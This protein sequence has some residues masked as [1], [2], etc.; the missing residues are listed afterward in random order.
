MFEYLIDDKFVCSNDKIAVG[1]SGGADSMLLLWALIDK[2]K[3]LGFEMLVIHINHGIRKETS[4]RDQKFVEDFCKKRK[5]NQISIKIDTKKLKNSE[6]LTLEEAA[7]TLRY[8]AFKKVIKEQKCNKLFLAHHKNDQAETILMHIF[9]GCGI[10]GASGMRQNDRTVR[11]FL[12]LS[13]D[14]ILSICKEHGIDF[15]VDETNESNDY[16]RNYVRNEIIPAIQ[17]IYPNAVDAVVRFGKRCEEI[18]NYI[19]AMASEGLIEETNGEVL[20]KDSAFDSESFVVKEYIKQAFEKIGIFEDVELKH[21]NAVAN[22]QKLEVNKQID[23][24][25]KVIAKRT[26]KGIK[27]YKDKKQTSNDLEYQFVIGTIELEGIGTIETKVVLPNEVEYGNGILF[28]D[29]NKISNE[30]V[31][32]TR[33]LGDVFSKLGTGCKK[34]NDYFTDKKIETSKRDSIPVLAIENSILVVAGEDISENVKIDGD[35]DR[36]VSIK[37]IK[38]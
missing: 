22:L 28:I 3:Q 8:D 25:H 7:R 38:N 29:Y 26:Y 32:R 1:V 30:S 31:W 33:K 12:K 17:K 36:I 10:L 19:E 6:K 14:E 21:Y 37:F 5:I 15:V 23:L 16:S 24:P 11:P 2:Q 18:Q 9:R 20:L 35:T 27:F 34:L 4:D 13:K